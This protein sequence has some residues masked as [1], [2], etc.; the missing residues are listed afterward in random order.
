[1]YISKKDRE[2]IKQKFAGKCAYTGTDLMENWQ[3]DHKVSIQHNHYYKGSALEIDVNHIDNL[4]P[5]Q[6]IINHYKR[7]LSL[8]GFRDYLRNFHLRL[9]KLP[10]KTTNKKTIKRIEYMQEI[11]RL[12]DITP[13]KPFNGVFYFET[14][15]L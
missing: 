6:R 5:A 2:I 15:T 13:D 9:A 12:F 7:S 14:L 11:A 4:V 10:K 1:M 8:E 3:V